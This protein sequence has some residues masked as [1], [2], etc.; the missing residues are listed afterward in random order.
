MLTLYNPSYNSLK[1][2][3]VRIGRY[4]DNAYIRE[5][6]LNLSHENW[7]NVFDAEHD[8][9]INVLFNNFLNTYLRIFYATFPI[10]KS[11]VKDTSKGWLTKGIL[12]SCRH[13]KDLYLLSKT[14]DNS[15]LKDYYKRYCRILTNIIQLVKKIHHNKLISQ[16]SNK[17]KIAWNVIRSLTKKQSNIKDE[18]MLNIEGT[19]IKNPQILSDIVNDYFFQSCG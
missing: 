4:Y 15:L 8:N 6:K 17:T 5:F 16:S 10:H 1:S 9:H 2:A 18:F 3:L 11:L 7:E 19:Q 13:K 12:T 14:S